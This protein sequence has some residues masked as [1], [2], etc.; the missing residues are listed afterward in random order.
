MTPFT[1]LYFF[2]AIFTCLALSALQLVT[3]INNSNAASVLKPVEGLP[4]FGIPILD[5]GRLKLCPKLPSEGTASCVQVIDFETSF[6]NRTL[7]YSLQAL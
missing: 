6:V 2:L 1:T 7:V 3:L 5:N 4:D